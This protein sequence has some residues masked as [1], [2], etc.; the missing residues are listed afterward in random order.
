MT[1]EIPTTQRALVFDTWN[2]PLEVR[3]VPVPSPADDEI[4]V[5][6]EYSGI[7][8]S[9]LH[10]WLGDLKGMSVCPLV[11][12]HEGA[13]SVVQIGK[14]VT[15]WQLGDKAGVKLM[16]FNC[17]NC[18]FCKKGHEPLCHHIQNYGFD[19]SGTFQEYLTI[20]GVDAAKINKETNLA[21]AAPILCAGVTVYKALKE[22]NV[23]PGQ[24]IVL[25]GAGG[26]LGSLAIQYAN[27]MGMRV[28]A[29]D[30]S[31]KEAHCKNLGAEWFVDAFD[32]PDIVSH[33]TKLTEGGPH[34]VINFAVARKPME[35]AVEYV[36]KRGTVVFVGLPKDSKVTFDTTPF[37]FNAITIKG[38]IVGS[39]LDVDEAM[40]FVT[41]GIVKVPL[42]LVKLEDVPAVYQRMIDGKITSRAV[43]DFSM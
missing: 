14:N 34:G 35:Q 18:E 29:M 23:K 33:I 32:T 4:L 13:G 6:I 40:E 8:H 39:R 19:R 2:G 21:A 28:V 26:G 1:V 42:E 37:I 12:G 9:D 24:I 27:A 36:R 11:G 20:R 22:S 15:G 25:T 41:R 10:V 17:L 43:V 31:S 30:H 38:S 5:K 7:C 16:N 3:Q